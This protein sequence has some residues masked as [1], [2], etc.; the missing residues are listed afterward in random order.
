MIQVRPAR[1]QDVPAIH[2]LIA[3]A[4]ERKLMVRRELREL[5]ETIC[6]LMVAVDDSGQVVGC[7][8]LHVFGPDYAELK[9]VAV[10]ETQRA[11]GVGRRLVAA[12]HDLAARLGVRTVFTLTQTPAFF[13]KCGYTVVDRAV[14]PR[15]IWSECVRCPF[16]PECRETALVIPIQVEPLQR[17]GAVGEDIPR[18]DL[19][20]AV[21]GVAVHPAS[22]G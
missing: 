8:G 22:R 11:R 5:Y 6:E 1:V 15:D 3:R 9:G 4:A 20:E 7:S 14:L 17:N 13:E 2:D 10:E 19:G 18:A 21:N 12:A 16:F